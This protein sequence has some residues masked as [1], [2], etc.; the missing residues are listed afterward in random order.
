MRQLILDIRPDSPAD[1]DNFLPGPNAEVLA[2]LREHAAGNGREAVVYVWGE[3]GIG[4]SHLLAAWGRVTAARSGRPLPEPPVAHLVVDD[5]DGLDADDQVRLF[6][7]INAARDGAGR[8]LASGPLPPTQLGLR[9]DLA[10]RLAQG[11]VFRLHALSDAD[12]LAALSIR[13]E[14]RGLRL[15]ED[16]AR[17]LITHGRRDLPHLLATVDALDDYSLSRKRPVSV[18]LLKEI[19]RRESSGS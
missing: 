17:Y 18:P 7:L 6:N 5:V 16:V 1:F 3:T 19:M 14:A 8:V 2:A 10:T 9:A 4:K 13:A 12:K 15:S 11:L